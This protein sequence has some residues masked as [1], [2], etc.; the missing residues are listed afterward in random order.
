MSC[1]GTTL[2]LELN[3]GYTPGA[4]CVTSLGSVFLCAERDVNND[5]CLPGLLE[6]ACGTCRASLQCLEP[7]FSGKAHSCSYFGHLSLE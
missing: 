3:P 5:T 2:T 7:A 4:H 6:A 1:V